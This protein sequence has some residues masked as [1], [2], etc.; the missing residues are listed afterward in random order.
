MQYEIKESSVIAAANHSTSQRRLKEFDWIELR[1]HGFVKLLF[2]RKTDCPSTLWVIRID[3]CFTGD[4]SCGWCPSGYP[5][6][7]QACD[8]ITYGVTVQG[9]ANPFEFLNKSTISQIHRRFLGLDLLYSQIDITWV[10]WQ[11]FSEPTLPGCDYS[12]QAKYEPYTHG[13]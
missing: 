12:F 10:E 13:D 2:I 1:S 11:R 9:S 7:L 3:I 6:I 8:S 4:G 5:H